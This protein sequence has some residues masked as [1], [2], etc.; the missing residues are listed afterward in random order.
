MEYNKLTERAQAVILEAENESEK[1][2]HGYVGTE[3]M[4][5]GILKEDGYSAKLLNKHG[6]DSEKIRAMIHRY[7]GYGDIKKTDDNILLTPRTKRLVDESFAAAKK[8]NH[9]YVSPE[10]ILLAL[11]NQEEGMAYTILKSLNL[12]FAIISEEL[13]AFLSGN[14]EDKVS[15]KNTMENKKADTPMLDKYGRDLTALSKEQ[16]LDPVIGRDNET[17]RLLEIL[18]RR[19]KNN[20][21]LIGEPG[22]GKTAVVE[23]LAQRIVEGNIPEILRS[24][25]VISLDLTSMIAGAK[26]RGEFEERLKKTM[27]EIIKDKDI[28]IFIDEIH[29]IIGAG[30]AEGAIDASN[31]L[32]PALAR[33][34]IQCIG[35]TTI[36]EY[37]KY[38]EKDSALERRFQP[39]VV[40]EPSKEETLEILKG[41]R[42]KYEAHHRVEITDEALEAAVNLS[43]RY[44][45]DR[46]M[47]DKAIDLID[48]GAAKVRIQSL[49]APPDLKDLE[50]RIENIGKEKEDAIRVQDFE[51]AASLRDKERELKDQLNNMKNN[52]DTQNSIKTLVVDAEKIASVVASWTKIPIR[53]LTESE[54]ERLLN[55]ENILHKRV[56]GQ[57]EAVKSIARAVRRARVGIKDPNRPI[58]S[59]IFLGPTGVGKTELSK[60]LAEAMFGDENSIIRV[61]MSE[62]MESH[63]VARLIGSPPGYVGYEEGGQLTEAVRRKPYS[64]VLLD[65]I[66]KANPEVF[67]ILLQIMEDGRL[68]DG[69]GKVVN[70]KNTIIIMTSN[71]GAHQIKKQKSIGFSSNSNNNEETEYEKMKENILGELKQKFRPE[72]LNRIDDTIVFHKLS[73]DDL[74]QIIDLMLA[75]IK[76]RLE[77]RDIYLNFEDNSKK[78]LLNKGIDLDYG[79]RP[80]R[81]LII[82]EVEDKLSE[83]IL[84]GNIRIGDRVSVSQLENKLVFRKS[85]KNDLEMN[86]S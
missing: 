25:R 37:R 14:Y 58:G 8:L 86:R 39:I 67:N 38:I 85:V 69:K 83:E 32:K 41:L 15:D 55:L 3:H 65:E 18:C 7:L 23:G 2:K 73:D 28:I 82:K 12:N 45:T 80:L 76:E 1:F 16:G 49:T 30:G 9:K 47:P 70:F 60:A 29:T 62:Y 6:I 19:I 74:N 57:N 24:K 44:I 26:Y 31:I 35:A 56:I 78:F 51:R 5:L 71:V 4:L 33:G 68:T 11:L 40:G 52:W 46:F 81:R 84:Q 75:S 17:Q 59:F 77:S 22:V 34:E 13:L 48:E 21:C 27:E 10:H 54:S 63:S 72:F 20:P 43:D 61:D 53:K 64:I 42:D 36:D 50:E 79:A 66:E